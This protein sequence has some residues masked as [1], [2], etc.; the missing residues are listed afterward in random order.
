MQYNV[1]VLGPM[2]RREGDTVVRP[3]STKLI[4]GLLEKMSAALA[5]GSQPPY[6]VMTPDEG[7]QGPIVE[8]VLD[9]I[10]E[11]DLVV[12]DL[13]GS[14]PSVAY[15]A[16]IVHALGIPHIFLTENAAEDTAFYFR[17]VNVISG[18]SLESE[19]D[20]AAPRPSHRDLFDRLRRFAGE[21]EARAEMAGNILTSHFEGLPLVD[22]SGP[23]GMA[24][25][26]YINSVRRFIRPGG[27]SD[28]GR[29]CTLLR[30]TRRVIKR[31]TVKKA[32]VKALVAIN[33]PSNL[34]ANHSSDWAAVQE[35]LRRHGIELVQATIRAEDKQDIRDFG[36]TFCKRGI[37]R[38]ST[39][40]V[41]LP[42]IVYPLTESP[43]IK[44]LNRRLRGLPDS[45]Q[46]ILRLVKQ[47]T[48]ERMLSS[49]QK[50]VQF[51]IDDERG[52]NREGFFY[53]PLDEV[54]ETLARLE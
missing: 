48:F 15:E 44:R 51:H 28:A 40:C 16:A 11:A 30:P 33:P 43:R 19:F 7:P 31:T 29:E 14:R 53:V 9:K 49:F 46:D 27:F 38:G 52:A 13:S 6:R 21:A 8:K 20:A 37:D 1:L 5:S 50:N 45:Q 3:A 39:V 35:E 25:S 32:R 4:A 22:T 36:G 42:T 12:I 24:A 17:G 10:E 2:E 18:F 41:E 34:V 54:P 26:Y 47:R 23:S